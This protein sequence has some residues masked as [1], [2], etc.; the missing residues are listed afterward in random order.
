MI[1][2]AGLY[3]DLASRIRTYMHQEVSCVMSNER[4]G[5]MDI[6]EYRRTRLH[7]FLIKL[8]EHCIPTEWQF[9]HPLPDFNN[10]QTKL[11]DKPSLNIVVPP[12]FR[13]II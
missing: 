8:I 9:Y 7:A 12:L 4:C 10:P 5:Y 2:G 13:T 6:L 3:T 11:K 1:R